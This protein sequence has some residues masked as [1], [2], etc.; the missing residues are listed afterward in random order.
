MINRPEATKI[1]YC[2]HYVLGECTQAH[3]NNCVGMTRCIRDLEN[4]FKKIVKICKNA[5]NVDSEL[6]MR[7]LEVLGSEVN[8]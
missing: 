8:E 3:H 5:P 4:K 2:S 1:N 6:S 7:I